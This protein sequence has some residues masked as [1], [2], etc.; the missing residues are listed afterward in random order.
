MQISGQNVDNMNKYAE[1]MTKKDKALYSSAAGLT[2]GSRVTKLTTPAKVLSWS[3][4]M[5]LETYTKQLQTWTEINEEVPEFL[6]F[7]NIIE[8]L[9]INKEIKGWLRYIAKHIV[10]VLIKKKDQTIDKVVR[11]LDVKYG[12]TRTEKVKECVDDLLKLREDQYEDDDE[13][14]LAMKKLNQKRQELKMN[15]E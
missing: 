13:L 2:P 4:D 10:P 11:L 15:Q 8:G 3:K 7:H 6:K 9:K 5:S 14:I 12:R 1:N